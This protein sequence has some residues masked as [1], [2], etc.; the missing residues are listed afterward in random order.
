[1]SERTGKQ[2]RKKNK[3]REKRYVSVFTWLTIFLA[4]LA[5]LLCALYFMLGWCL[6]AYYVSE[7]RKGIYHVELEK[8]FAGFHY[9]DEYIIWYNIGNYYFDKGDYGKAEDAYL[10]SID[11]GIPF[12]KECPVKV[13]LALSMMGQIDEDDWDEFFDCTG[14]ENISAGARRVEKILKDARDVLIQDGCAHEDDKDGHDK[15]AQL[16][17]DEIDELLERSSL[18]DEEE[19]EDEDEEEDGDDGD[20]DEEEEEEDGEDD[21]DD[22][23]DEEEIMEHIQDMLDENQEERADEQEVYQD[24]YGIGL[25]DTDFDGEHGDVW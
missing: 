1:M 3:T 9:P 8:F 16:L 18:D 14:P 24:L 12:E 23:I 19:D 21:G 10:Q 11:C 6:N 2:K 13:N 7:A 5:T 22:S 4:G 17:K 25:D 20:E 15:Q